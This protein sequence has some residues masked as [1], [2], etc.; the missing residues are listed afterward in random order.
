MKTI[1]PAVLLLSAISWLAF[2]AGKASVSPKKA[3]IRI[4]RLEVDSTQLDLYCTLL[5]EEIAASIK[6]EPGVLTLYA[7]AEKDN[8]N[9]ITVFE[10]YAD[11]TAYRSHL[12]TPHFKKYKTGTQNM[13][14]SL[15]LKEV[16]PILLGRK[17]KM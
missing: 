10:I 15:D 6:L 3:M 5:K 16:E 13:V 7:V 14:Q 1:L 4:A 9:R 12:E 17:K 11:E 8:P 2:R